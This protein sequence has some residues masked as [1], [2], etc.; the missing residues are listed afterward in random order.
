MIGHHAIYKVEDVSMIYI[1]SAGPSLNAE[2]QR[3]SKLF[4]VCSLIYSLFIA[5]SAL[6]S[7]D[8]TTDF[9]FSFT[10]D[11]SHNLQEN[12]IKARSVSGAEDVQKPFGNG[13]M[14]DDKFVWNNYLLQPLRAHQI[15]EKWTLHVIHGFIGLLLP[16][17]L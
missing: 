15:S 8:L 7:V 17:L 9:F 3:Y 14:A 6:Q 12:V 10:Y 2:E 1:P 16:F 11:L 13:L 4:Q 5:A